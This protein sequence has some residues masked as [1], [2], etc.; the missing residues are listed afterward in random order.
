MLIV[1]LSQFLE[2][3]ITSGLSGLHWDLVYA[4][5]VFVFLFSIK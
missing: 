3:L 1:I 5:K 2:R 4:L